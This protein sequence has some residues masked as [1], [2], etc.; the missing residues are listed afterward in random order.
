MSMDLCKYMV[1]S[2]YTTT[3]L[4]ISIKAAIKKSGADLWEIN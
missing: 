3:K 1:T 4:D 2:L